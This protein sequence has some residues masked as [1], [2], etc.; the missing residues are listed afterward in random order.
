MTKTDIYIG[1]NDQDTKE[2]KF[3]TEKYVSVLKN[4]CVSYRVSFSFNLIRGGYIHESGEYTQ[5]NTLVLTL[6]DT[7]RAVIEEIARD[8]CTFFR[9]ESVLI[10]SSEVDTYSVRS[11]L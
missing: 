9:Q 10:T 11:G 3:A 7:E 4:V 6:I 2:Q 5:E 8:L 1:L